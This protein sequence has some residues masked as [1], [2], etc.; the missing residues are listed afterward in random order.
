MSAIALR[1]GKQCQGPQSVA[2]PSSAN[3]PAQLHSTPEKDDDKNLK[4]KLPNNF[5][6][7]ES[8]TSNSDLQK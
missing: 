6:A 4:S 3:E 2:S 8:S 5:Y 7:G 1:L